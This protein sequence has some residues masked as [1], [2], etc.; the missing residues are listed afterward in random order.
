MNKQNLKKYIIP[1]SPGVYFFRKGTQVIYVGKATSLRDRVR[2]YFVK[3]LFETRGPILVEMLLQSDNI[4]WKQAD[5]VLEALILES[6]LI[7]KYQPKYNTKEKSDKSFN[8]VCITN[9]EIPKVMVIRGKQV[10]EIKNFRNCALGDKKAG[11]PH[12]SKNSLFPL[13]ANFGPF[14]NS[15][16]LKEALKIVRRIFAFVDESSNK[17]QNYEFYRQLKLI[18]SSLEIYKNNI[19][20]IILFFKGKKKQILK[21]LEKEMKICVKKMEFEKANQIKKQIFALKHINDVALIKEGNG[22]VSSNFLSLRPSPSTGW[23]PRAQKIGRNFSHL[24]FFRIESYDIAHMSGQ[25]MVGVMTVIQDGEIVKNEYKKFSA[26]G[27]SAFGGRTVLGNSKANDTGALR[28]ILERRFNHTEWQYP[29]LIVVDGGKMQISVAK[30]IIA[31]NGLRIPI[32][33]VV[34]DQKHKPKGI[35]GDKI[36]IQKYKNQILLANNES[37]RFAIAYHKKVRAKNFLK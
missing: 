28:E 18:P 9:E 4:K 11:D 23:D 13:L 15:S 1:D 10:E 33:S 36:L 37:H 21:N 32:V 30:K 26:K 2:S 8:Y 17:K 22:F 12:V 34:K 14:T 25:N 27:G 29:N 35:L 24:N 5:S 3:D 6:E 31:K 20:N 16:Q 7:K 19:K